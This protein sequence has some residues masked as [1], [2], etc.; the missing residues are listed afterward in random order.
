MY[1]TCGK[2]YQCTDEETNKKIQSNLT[3]KVHIAME[4]LEKRNDPIIIN[5][6]KGGFVVVMETGS[7]IKETNLQLCYKRS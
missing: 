4:D 6:D 5:A 1:R 3:N 7:Y 2:W